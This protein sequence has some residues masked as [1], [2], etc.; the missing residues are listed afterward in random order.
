MRVLELQLLFPDANRTCF[1]KSPKEPSN[2]GMRGNPR[3]LNRYL[4]LE[5]EQTELV[6][7]LKVFTIGVTY[8]MPMD[9]ILGALEVIE[10]HAFTLLAPIGRVVSTSP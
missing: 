3:P 2:V 8:C 7:S 10:K 4:P 6:S 9:I 5:G 1:S